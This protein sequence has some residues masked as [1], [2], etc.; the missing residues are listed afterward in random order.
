MSPQSAHTHVAHI[1]SRHKDQSIGS[2][3]TLTGNKDHVD[4]QNPSVMSLGPSR[5]I[6][7]PLLGYKEPISR[8]ESF[9]IGSEGL[10]LT[11]SLSRHKALLLDNGH[12][13][14]HLTLH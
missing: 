13:G 11:G 8:Y 3:G 1:I 4:P 5:A 9:T 10:R 6:K 2:H 12:C 14:I 7:G